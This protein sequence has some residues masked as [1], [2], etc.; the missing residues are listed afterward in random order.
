M[1]KREKRLAAVQARLQ[2]VAT[3][4]DFALVLEPHALTEAHRLTETLTADGDLQA[5]YL[6]G[7]LHWYS[8]QAL[9]EGQDREDLNAAI[10]MFILCFI[11]DAAELPEPLQPILAEQA[12]PT[13]I[14]WLEEALGST[15]P[16]LLS[17]VIDLWQRILAA[18]PADHPG[19]A[20]CLSNFG[21]ALQSRFERTG[22]Q[23]DLD[24]GHR[25]PAR[26]VSGSPADHPDRP[27]MLS[28]LG[29]R[30]ADPVRAHRGSRP[31]WTQAIDRPPGGC[32]PPLRPT[33]PTGPGACSTS[34]MRCGPGSSTPGEPADLDAGHHLISGRLS[35]PPRPTTP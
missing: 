20:R 8:Y 22:Q 18:T 24:A 6:L 13:A 7:W 28:N 14:A 3:A 4:R 33:T 32:A 27:A 30:A 23:A 5:R 1:G 35:P 9:P 11:A 29:D 2:Q 26:G 16:A 31:T 12:T 15:N 34:G 17:A 19:R 10:G 25:G 21:I